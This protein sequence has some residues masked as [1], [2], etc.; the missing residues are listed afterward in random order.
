M[1]YIQPDLTGKTRSLDENGKVDKSL[2][3]RE[4][5]I[6]SEKKK[7]KKGG[8]KNV[9]IKRRTVY[10]NQSLYTSE[11]NKYKEKINQIKSNQTKGYQSPITSSSSVGPGAGGLFSSSSTS[12]ILS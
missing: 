5:K 1:N 3:S 4:R 2:H 10:I 7:K 12:S 6:K 11:K 9:P 8:G